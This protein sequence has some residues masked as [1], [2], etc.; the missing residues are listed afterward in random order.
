M[1]FFNKSNNQRW[2]NPPFFLAGIIL[3]SACS[4]DEMTV[5]RETTFESDFSAMPTALRVDMESSRRIIAVSSLHGGEATEYRIE[6]S[7]EWAQA[8]ATDE[9]LEI[10]FADNNSDNERQGTLVLVQ[11]V[12][13]QRLEVAL[14]QRYIAFPTDV[15]I[16]A[17]PLPNS[18]KVLT[19]DFQYTMFGFTEE[20]DYCETGHYISNTEPFRHEEEYFATGSLQGIPMTYTDVA[21]SGWCNEGKGNGVSR[22]FLAFNR[23]SVREG[24][25]SAMEVG[26][27]SS[28]QVVRFSLSALSL[29]GRG[30]ALYRTADSG[31][32]WE[33]VGVFKPTQAGKGEWFSVGLGKSGVSLRFAPLGETGYLRMHD[34][35]VYA[36]PFTHDGEIIIS[37]NFQHWTR[38]GFVISETGDPCSW[39]MKATGL[40][41]I[42]SLEGNPNG[43][44]TY[45]RWTVTWSMEDYG[46]NP[47]CGNDAGTSTTGSEVS[48]GYFAFQS[49]LYYVCGGHSSMAYLA[50]SEFP[51]VSKVRFSFSY[52]RSGIEYTYGITLWKR[53]RSDTRWIKVKRC[54]IEG[55]TEEKTA[56]KVFEAEI[57]EDYVRLGFTANWGLLS[58]GE[59]MTYSPPPYDNFVW[60]KEQEERIPL[61][62]LTYNFNA[63]LHDLTVWCRKHE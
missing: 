33:P 28:V 59:D 41:F 57:D 16:N 24:M 45:P 44:K 1:G 51:S 32:G 29:E 2:G 30:L 9:G 39:R 42:Q 31:E 3:F 21:V 20:R 48:E 7:P 61:N 10:R 62:N 22:G 15:D 4:G 53:S 36:M 18:E 56:G 58:S 8:A 27:F 63:R 35:E 52:A 23:R 43:V 46:V 17:T 26:P 47:S 14:S 50:S 6:N 60:Y 11:P 19:K 5:A 13:G 55:G 12:S 37:E 38:E 54:E 34:L 40:M 25:Q 49:P